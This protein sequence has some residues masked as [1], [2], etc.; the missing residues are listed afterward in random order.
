MKQSWKRISLLAVSLLFLTAAGYSADTKATSVTVVGLYSETS[1]GY[2]SFRKAGASE[3]TVAKVG[4]LIPTTAELKVNV[5]QDWLEFVATGKPTE[6]YELLGPGK[7]ELVRKVSEI[8]KGKP[9]IVTF[10]KGSAAKPDPAFKD[11]LAV[12]QYLGRQIYRSESGESRDIKY[13][14]VLAQGGKVKII[15]INNTLTLMNASGAVTNVIG[16]LN[17]TIEQVLSNKSLYKFLNVQK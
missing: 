14:D 5:E 13:G 10:P 7:G 6:V 9:R 12:T 15:A 4:D 3:W 2:V 11:K 16:P 1:D 8:L 17:F